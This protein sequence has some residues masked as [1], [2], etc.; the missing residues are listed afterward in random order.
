MIDWF[1]SLVGILTLAIYGICFISAWISGFLKLVKYV[2]LRAKINC[3]STGL[4]PMATE[5][6]LIVCEALEML[7]DSFDGFDCGFGG[8]F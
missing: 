2:K 5:E 4:E 7:S 1:L 3:I 6:T 8:D